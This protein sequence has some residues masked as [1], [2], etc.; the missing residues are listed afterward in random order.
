MP[1]IWSSVSTQAIL[2]W[3]LGFFCVCPQT[4]IVKIEFLL[5]LCVVVFT[6]CT[7]VKRN[8]CEMLIP[9]TISTPCVRDLNPLQGLNPLLVFPSCVLLC[10][11]LG[12]A[13][14]L[15]ALNLGVNSLHR[16]GNNVGTN[17]VGFFK[18][19]R[20]RHP[21]CGMGRE[22]LGPFQFYVGSGSHGDEEGSQ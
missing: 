11:V 8:G 22:R 17:G 14:L 19:W 5:S 3:V 20:S 4:S 16:I 1:F 2:E 6:H 9:K 10:N 18:V 7:A 21:L 12:M 13:D 15:L